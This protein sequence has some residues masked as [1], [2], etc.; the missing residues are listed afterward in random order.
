MWSCVPPSADA[1]CEVHDGYCY[2]NST[3]CLVKAGGISPVV[4]I[5]EGKDRQADEAV[6]SA[7]ATLLQDEIWENGSDSIA[8]TSGIQ[9]I[10]KVLESGN[11]KA[12][13]KAL[14]I[15]E[16]ILRVDEYRVQHGESAQVVLIDVAQNG[17]PRLK[18]TIAKLLAQLELLQI[19]SIYF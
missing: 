2:V 4:Q 8:K 9:A 1:Y 10:I 16:R 5:L 6:L 15:L 17:D 12:Q 18:P 7:L 11:V 3:F 14:W 19:Q 13:E